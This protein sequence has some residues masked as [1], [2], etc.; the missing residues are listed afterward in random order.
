MLMNYIVF[1]KSW[2][3][4]QKI[5]ISSKCNLFTAEIIKSLLRANNDKRIISIHSIER[6][7]YGM[8]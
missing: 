6:Y 5:G 4:G 2:K 8:S 1:R 3:M 7:A